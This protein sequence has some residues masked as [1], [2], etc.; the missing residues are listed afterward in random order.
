MPFVRSKF[1]FL[2]VEL[3]HMASQQQDEHDAGKLQQGLGQVRC[4]LATCAGRQA[5]VGEAGA[6]TRAVPCR[7]LP[8]FPSS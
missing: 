4:W 2:P 8:C 7:H 6:I 1:Q 3:Q 5:G